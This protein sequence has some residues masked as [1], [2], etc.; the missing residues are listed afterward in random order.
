MHVVYM[1]LCKYTA[2]RR[3]VLPCDSHDGRNLCIYISGSFVISTVGK[4]WVGVASL[5][6]NLCLDNLLWSVLP[7]WIKNLSGDG[8]RGM[9]E[10]Y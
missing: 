7:F 3:S 10:G 5:N 1:H 6:V 9:R 8:M 4:N 2:G